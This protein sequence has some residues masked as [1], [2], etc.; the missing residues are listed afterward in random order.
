[1]NFVCTYEIYKE[2]NIKKLELIFKGLKKAFDTVV[3][4]ILQINL[5]H[6]LRLIK[7]VKTLHGKS[8]AMCSN[9]WDKFSYHQF[10][11]GFP[12]VHGWGHCYFFCA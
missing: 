9:K 12:R 8:R 3:H 4:K 5:K 7:L 6:G 11:V 1:M 10:V 2:N